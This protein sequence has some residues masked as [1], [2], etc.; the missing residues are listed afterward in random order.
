[1]SN[2]HQSENPDTETG[3]GRG[4]HWVQCWT[5]SGCDVGA[6]RTRGEHDPGVVHGCDRRA[7]V[8]KRKMEE[9]SRARARASAGQKT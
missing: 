7:C 4:D 8:K 3:G 2:I 5:P 1:M 6:P 9:D